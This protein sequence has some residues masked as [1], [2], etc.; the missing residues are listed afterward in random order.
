MPLIATNIQRY[1]R[2]TIHDFYDFPQALFAVNYPAPGSPE[3]AENIQDMTSQPSLDKDSKKQKGHHHKN[4]SS[5]FRRKNVSFKFR[6][7]ECLAEFH[8][9]SPDF[10]SRNNLCRHREKLRIYLSHSLDQSKSC[11]PHL[12]QGSVRFHKRSLMRKYP[13]GSRRIHQGN[14]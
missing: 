8:S 3:T 5:S 4:S 9:K 2:Q 7:G 6:E 1:F 13:S 10:F 14:P 11:H 12:S